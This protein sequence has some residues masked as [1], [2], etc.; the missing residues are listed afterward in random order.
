MAQKKSNSK[1][2]KTKTSAKVR[3]NVR[4]KENLIE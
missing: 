2:K 3:N 4:K 1:T